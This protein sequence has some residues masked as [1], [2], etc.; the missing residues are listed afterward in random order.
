MRDK[1]PIRLSPEQIQ[2]IMEEVHDIFGTDAHAWL[3]GS[4]T[5]PQARGG[6]IDLYIEVDATAE[7][8][9]Q[10]E[11]SLY[12]RLIRRLGDQKIDIVVH[13]TGTPM[14]PIHEEAR[15]TGV[16]LH[17]LRENVNDRA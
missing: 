11:L 14:Q 6:D 2:A 9:L 4:R 1:Q 8:A 15:S 16:P 3:F 10:R 17:L 5:D 13:R 12:A 7:E